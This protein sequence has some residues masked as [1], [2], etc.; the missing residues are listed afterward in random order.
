MIGNGSDDIL[1]MAFLAFFQTESPVLFPD[2]NLWVLDK[3][4]A[5]LYGVPYEEVPL[6]TDFSWHCSSL[7]EG[8]W[9]YY[10]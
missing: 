3:V 4:W 7:S 10:S 6:R 5:Q 8:M 2:L 1:S 9:R